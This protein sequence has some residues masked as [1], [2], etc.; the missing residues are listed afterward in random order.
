MTVTEPP[1]K[2]VIATAIVTDSTKSISWMVDLKHSGRALGSLIGSDSDAP[3]PTAK[4]SVDIFKI[5]VVQK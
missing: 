1:R 3:S 2:E 4:A 5:Q